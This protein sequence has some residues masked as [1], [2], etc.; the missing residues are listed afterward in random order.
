M[1][2]V[3]VQ[4][5]VDK[6]T[7]VNALT[8]SHDSRLQCIDARED[9]MTSRINRWLATVVDELHEREELRRNRSRVMEISCFIDRCREDVDNV[10]MM[11]D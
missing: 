7:L 4:L 9:D 10:E 11:I 8:S 3:G 2:C 6:E 5:L 1:S